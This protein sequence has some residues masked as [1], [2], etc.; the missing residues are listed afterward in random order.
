MDSKIRI[1]ILDDNEIQQKIILRPIINDPSYDIK[2][3][4]RSLDFLNNLESGTDIAIVDYYID[5]LDG[6]EIVKQIKKRSKQTIVIGLSV[7]EKIEVAIDFIE[8]GAWRYV[9]MNENGHKKILK[10]V[11]EATLLIESNK[12]FLEEMKQLI[13]N[14]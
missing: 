8:A 2:V 14:S 7:Q 4:K 10:L 6:I 5:E 13:K 3:F 11:K 1:S 12:K 9:V